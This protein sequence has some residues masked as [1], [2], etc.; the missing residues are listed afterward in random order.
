[1]DGEKGMIYQ[2]RNTTDDRE[3][4]TSLQSSISVPSIRTEHLKEFRTP[5][6]GFD[7]VHVDLSLEHIITVGALYTVQKGLS[8]RDRQWLRN[9][10]TI[11]INLGFHLAQG[12][13]IMPL[14]LWDGCDFLKEPYSSMNSDL[15][16]ICLVLNPQTEAETAF[17]A[18]A[19]MFG[20]RDC[21]VSGEHKKEGSWRSAVEKSSPKI[22]VTFSEID[23]SR[24]VRGCDLSGPSYLPGPVSTVSAVSLQT[25]LHSA[26]HFRMET[27]LRKDVAQII[28]SNGIH[29]FEETAMMTFDS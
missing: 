21:R 22:V 2:H 23:N 25:K 11:S 13:R 4:A 28:E 18:K 24:E 26:R 27:L 7:I 1:M 29:Q 15:L 16:V 5:T 17:C 20:A 10:I 9:A 8:R 12:F 6:N 3:E 19:T 14:N